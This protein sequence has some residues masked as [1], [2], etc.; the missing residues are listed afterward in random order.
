M[1]LWEGREGVLTIPGTLIN[2]GSDVLWIV[3]NK[4]LI[5]SITS[6]YDEENGLEQ[7]STLLDLLLQVSKFVFNSTSSSCVISSKATL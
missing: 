3:F 1:C 2:T 5:F 7:V 4:Y 6:M